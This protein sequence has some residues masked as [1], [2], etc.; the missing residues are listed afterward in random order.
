MGKSKELAE[1]GQVVTQSGGN[2]GIGASVPEYALHLKGSYP[3]IAFED[4]DSGSTSQHTITGNSD[5][6]M[7]FDSVINNASGNSGFRFRH[8]SASITSLAIDA[9]GRVTMPYQPAFAAYVNGVG[10]NSGFTSP[11]TPLPYQWDHV[12]IGGH[13][14]TTTSTFTAPISGTYAMNASASYG[15]NSVANK[16]VAIRFV[17]NGSVYYSNGYALD[18]VQV[19][20]NNNSYGNVALSDIFYLNANDT[21]CVQAQYNTFN[22]NLAFG[23]FSGHLIG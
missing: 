21:V 14:N 9:S 17:V 19:G 7:Y 15:N 2:V 13:Y 3:Y 8:N 12:N 20:P 23:C 22:G 4:T 6:N 5:G 1:L 18:S 10:L 11:T 16:W